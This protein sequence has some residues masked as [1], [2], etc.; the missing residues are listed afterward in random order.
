[1]HKGSILTKVRITGYDDEELENVTDPEQENLD[2]HNDKGGNSK[3]KHDDINCDD[4][5]STDNVYVTRFLESSGSSS[6]LI[7]RVQSIL[8]RY[9]LNVLYAQYVLCALYVL[10]VLLTRASQLVCHPASIHIFPSITISLP[11]SLSVFPVYFE[12]F[13]HFFVLSHLLLSLLFLNFFFPPSFI[14]VFFLL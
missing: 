11:F 1:M 4:S 10:C 5:V 6:F 13:V 9:V 2:T 14:L 3:R 8:K 7:V 12:I